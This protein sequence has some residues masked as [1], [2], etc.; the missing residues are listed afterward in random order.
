MLNTVTGI[1]KQFIK[2]ICGFILPRFMLV[3][4]GSST[5]GLVSSIDHYL[6]FIS[7]LDMGVGSVVL[8]NLYKPLANKDNDQI[9]RIIKSSQRFFRTLAFIFLVYIAILV[10][11][12]PTI[13]NTKYDSL[14][15]VSLLLIIAI[16]TFVEYYFGITNKLLLD[17]DQKSYIPLSLM[18]IT[19][20]LNTI[21]AIVL[22]K[23][24]AGIHVVKLASAAVYVVRPICQELYIKAHYSINKKIELQGEPIKQ[25]W[26]G[27]SQHLAAV[28]CQNIDVVALSFFSTM[29]NVSVYSLY[30]TVANGV[31]QVV[32]TAAT[33]V[34]SL[35]GNM[36]ANNEINTLNRTFSRIEWFVHNVVTVIFTIAAITIVPFMMVYTRGITD[37]EYRQPLFG[38]LLLAA[39][40]AMCLRVPYFRIIKAAGHFKQTQN[41]AYIA[42][43]INIVITLFLVSRFGLIGA[44]VGT[45]LALTFHTCYFV[46]YLNSN[47]MFRPI[48]YFIFY[49][50]I[51]AA[52]VITSTIL[53]RGFILGSITYISW[54]LLAIEVG[55][56]TLASSIVINLLFCRRQVLDLWRII[57]EKSQL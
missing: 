50:L 20:S 7:L 30:Y 49:I 47:I 31:E 34:E 21:I 15:S 41:G 39:Y 45:L 38:A 12:F 44:A 10:V 19:I 52:V 33:G 8:S 1:S 43:T 9:S 36:L 17:A 42:A 32:M 4:F 51:D 29:E 11:V 23:L 27:F 28:V 55:L 56:V 13:I 37:A 6:G 57:I 14:F 24:G 53:S 3:Y 26:N 16:S 40:A 5:N 48:R 54:I 18:I 2:M 46:W 35:F 25:K 22:M